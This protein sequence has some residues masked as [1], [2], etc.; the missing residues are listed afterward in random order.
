MNQARPLRL[1]LGLFV[2]IL[3]IVTVTCFL[4]SATTAQTASEPSP[5]DV[6]KLTGLMT[7]MGPFFQKIQSRVQSPAP[8]NQ[9]HL[10]PLLPESTILYA[11]FPNYGE[12]SHQVLTLFREEVKEN[13]KLRAWWT[14]GEMATE[15]PKIEN[16]LEKLYELSEYLGDEIV[17]SATSSGNADP[18][19]VLLAEVRKPGFKEALPKILKEL[20]PKSSKT[21]RVLD[22]AELAA[23]NDAPGTDQPV[24]LVRPDFVAFGENLATIRTFNASLDR[25]SQGFASGG[26]G[27]RIAQ[28]YEGGVTIVAGLDVQTVLKCHGPK[29]NQTRATLE[30]TGFSDMKYLVW[31]HKTVNAHQTSQ[32]ELSFTGP[33]RGIAAWLAA[34]GPIGSLDFVSPNALMVASMLL[35]DPPHIFDDVAGLATASN[36]KA[37]DSLDQMEQALHLNLRNDLLAR[38]GG[39]ITV[40]LDT[41]PPQNPV[42]KVF[43]KATDPPGLLET[44]R[45]FFAASRMMP[46]ESEQD[47]ISYYTLRIPN[48]NKTMEIGYAIAD[49]YLVVASSRDAVADAIRLHRGGESLAKSGKLATYLPQSASGSDVSA[50]L[51]EDPIAMAALN[52][53]RFSPELANS[54]IQRSVDAPPTVMAFYGDESALREASQSGAFDVTTPLIVSAIAIPNLL[55]ARMAANDSSAVAIVRTANTA[56]IT[57]EATYPQNGY[58]PDFAALGSNPA[59]PN[60]YSP[61][62][63]GLIESTLGNPT[64]TAGTWCIKSGY[65]FTITTACKLQKCREYVVTA[66]PVSSSTGTRNFCSTSDAVVRFQLASPLNS[67]LR[68]AECRTWPPL[69]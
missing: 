62:H 37:M 40:E 7:E 43:L 31:T 12:T 3:F 8:R 54:L 11:A 36:P 6:K 45:T 29:D 23:A 60:D 50:L 2:Q 61:Q 30:R 52:L 19:F 24:V 47:G 64:C 9:S 18:K 58:A 4:T 16:A 55:R 14:Q 66:T 56:E 68:A 35:Q 39:E 63:A 65:R 13:A 32:F 69:Q 10:L 41:L 46:V 42:W 34:P 59:Q 57:Y 26:F 25:N 21:F 67:P 17:I 27:R 48:A 51:Y 5:E 20:D 49:G 28:E 44:L 38:L 15:G 1:R 53:Q 33:R 22:V